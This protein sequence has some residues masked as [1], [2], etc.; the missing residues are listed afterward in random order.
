M[1]VV[2]ILLLGFVSL[3]KIPLNLLPDITYPKITIRTEYPH[4]APREV[5][6]RVTKFIES[7]VGIINNVVKV[8]SVSRPDWSDVY[9]EFK[10]GSDVDVIAMDIREKIQLL[11]SILPEEVERPV[12]LRYDPN[13]DPI[14]T[15]AVGGDADLATLRRWVEMN[16]ELELERLDGVAA[17]KVEGGYEDEIIIEIDEEKLSR[18]G[19]RVSTIVERLKSEN[20][21]VAGGSI[22][23]GGD[24]LAVRTVN[25][26]QE[27]ESI[28]DM[29]IAERTGSSGSG[30]STS[31]VSSGM[32]G[33]SSS[34]MGGMGGMG[35][36]GGM[37]SLLAL[38][39]GSASSSSSASGS[40]ETRAATIRIRDVATVSRKHKERTEI[41]RL[42]GKECIKVSVFKEG[43]AN[44][45]TVARSVHDTVA[46]IK[47][48]HRSGVR[49]EEWEKKLKDPVRKLKSA[50]NGLLGLLLNYRPF[51]IEEEPVEM[52]NGVE[53]KVISDQ[54]VFI[55]QS[56]YSVAQTAIWGAFFA[57]VVLYVFLRNF[58]STFIVGLSIPVS[59]IA[60]FNLMFFRDISFNIMSLGGLA[61][62]VG[63]LVDNSIVVIENILRRRVFEPDAELSALR[64]AEEVS[65]AITASTLT[66]IMVFFP[67]LYL[68]GMFRQIF[69]DLAWAVAFSLIC[70]ELV[71]LSLAP[72]LS[73]VLGKRVRLPKELLSEMDL[74]E[75]V[76]A[77]AKDEGSPP[78][79]KSE[80]SRLRFLALP[81][82]AF[83]VF[84][85]GL[86]R[87]YPKQ[88]RLVLA[89]PYLVCLIAMIVSVGSVGVIYVI[90][91][92]LL[93][94]V[95]Q[96]EFR[97]RAEFP[98]G[99]PIEETNDKMG[100]IES[101]IREVRN[102][103]LITS[104][105]TTVGIST[106][107]GEG[108]SE[109]SENLGEVHVSL[110]ESDQRSV[111]DEAIIDEVTTALSRDIVGLVGLRSAKPQL[112]SYKTPIE[113][114][115]EG[116]DLDKLVMASE[117]IVAALEK[118]V[119]KDGRE[120]PAIPG[121]AEIESSL[122]EENP[123]VNIAIDRDRAA[124]FG[125]SVTEISNV[126]Q[127]KVKGELASSYDLPDQ[128]IDIRV[129]LEKDDRD[130]MERLQRI[131]IPCAQ[132]EV[133]L[134]QLARVEIGAG[135]AT[136]TRSENSRVAIIRGNIHGRPL[137]DVVADIERDLN[138]ITLPAGYVW[139]ITGQ[140][141]EMKRSM[142]S[143]Y[144]AAL[145][146]LMLV[147]IV[148]ASQFESLVHPFVIMFCVPFSLIGL[149]LILI[150]TGQ[151]INIFSLIGMLMMIGIAV[152]D[153]IV[154]V[155]TINQRR[156]EGLER[157]E[158]IVDAG[159]T[160]LRPILITTLTTVL[161]MAPMAIALGPGA[162]LRAPMAIT[163][164]GGLIAST[165]MTLTTIPCVYLILD[166]ILPRSYKP[167]AV[168][169]EGGVSIET[170]KAGEPEKKGPGTETAKDKP[171]AGGQTG[172]NDERSS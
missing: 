60:T 59:I 97:I 161:G 169:E 104:L 82:A 121:L 71:A 166:K 65:S 56:I 94:P 74:P 49:N 13:Q 114:E 162:E 2:G 80:K 160:R 53:I 15:M 76:L 110:V 149:A 32:G 98:I 34:M 105:F 157:I 27:L 93:P 171:T 28:R 33:A 79:K 70:S 14:I 106:A 87:W 96:S 55:I 86:K 43:D 172:G 118:K 92:E 47:D 83:D 41:A 147:Y 116:P 125:V 26:F 136:I 144:L 127:G 40:E 75:G 108:A 4:A 22:E 38:S 67:I 129:Q 66:N 69:G 9:V 153:A 42:E 11:E 91:W 95:D 170:V 141:E 16:V 29:I 73:V 6:E 18:L 35:G 150:L 85:N 1:I 113:I 88:L 84:F 24:E 139:R 51:F 126:I 120:F 119:E 100:E 142:P 103:D 25:R 124:S 30:S 134:D 151:T 48:K 8:S 37:G 61:L 154:F 101:R 89:H 68:E 148:L 57:V 111:S 44:I 165:F 122:G 78:G 140:N 133:R 152:N 39:A 146:A 102:A 138:K 5:E 99:T 90:G 115:I 81:L 135:P 46:E 132:G 168:R 137:G 159:S 156:D 107:E 31:S 112:L 163:V 123:E 52:E 128:Q 10:W 45:V 117:T 54:S 50:A 109:K 158:A 19:L 58:S 143:L 62:G 17:V 131:M 164:I 20:V 3:Q 167:K 72:M 23:E 12:L 145:L 21:N 64:G 36:L 7:S 77:Q 63:M 155:T 130:T